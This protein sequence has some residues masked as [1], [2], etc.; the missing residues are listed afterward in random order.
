MSSDLAKAVLVAGISSVGINP[1]LKQL[2]V[3]LDQ[4]TLLRGKSRKYLSE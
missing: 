1:K 4:I 3:R 2:R